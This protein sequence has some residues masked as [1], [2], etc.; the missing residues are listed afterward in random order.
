MIE[1]INSIADDGINDYYNDSEG[2]EK[3]DREHIMRSRLR[4]DTR[5]WIACKALP[6]VYGEKSQLV[7]DIAANVQ[8]INSTITDPVEAARIYQKIMQ[9]DP[10]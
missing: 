6:K 3:P 2:N 9:D 7:L 4:V 10:A 5:K 1:E 8:S